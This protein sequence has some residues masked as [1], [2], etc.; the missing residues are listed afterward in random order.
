MYAKSDLKFCK[1]SEILRKSLKAKK[2]KT[3]N[4]KKTVN[5]DSY[6]VK[7][8]NFNIDSDFFITLYFHHLTIYNIIQ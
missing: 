8:K 2:P 4:Y 6:T 7:N 5:S 3:W 1:K